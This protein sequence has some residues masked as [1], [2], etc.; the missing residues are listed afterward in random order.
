MLGF[1]CCVVVQRGLC[2]HSADMQPDPCCRLPP[3]A[4]LSFSQTHRSLTSRP[5]PY[6]LSLQEGIHPLLAAALPSD[7]LGGLE[8]Q[9][10]LAQIAAQ[11]K[12]YR[13]SQTVFEAEV[14]SA[15]K[16]QGAGAFSTY[17]L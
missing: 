12:S 1:V 5:R 11:L 4:L 15:R 13:P 2:A 10:S 16:G 14:A 9:T 8:A 17:R 6:L 3:T 7:A